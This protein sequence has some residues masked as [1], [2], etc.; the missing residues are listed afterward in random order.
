MRTTEGLGVFGLHTLDINILPSKKGTPLFRA[1]QLYGF[2]SYCICM[3]CRF[4]HQQPQDIT[5]LPSQKGT[6]LL[7]LLT[8]PWECAFDFAGSGISNPLDI[9]I[10]PSKKGL[11]AA[12]KQKHHHKAAG[13]GSK[14]NKSSRGGERKRRQKAAEARRAAKAAAHDRQQKMEAATGS[15]GLFAFI[16][17]N[18]GSGSEAAEKL[19][20]AGVYGGSRGSKQR[21][22]QQQQSTGGAAALASAAAAAAGGGGSSKGWQQQQP[23]RRGLIGSQDDLAQK[24]VRAV[25]FGQGLG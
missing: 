17:Y 25:C 13:M 11:G 19:R 1:A 10:L 21:Q 22:Q 7:S 24:K 2:V 3:L 20:D 12:K 23:D 8:D 14:K 6:P 16:N 9:T 15:E 4:R 5:I 18:L